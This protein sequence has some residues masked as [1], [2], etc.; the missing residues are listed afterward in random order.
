[1]KVLVKEP[2]KKPVVKERYQ[3]GTI[4]GKR[5]DDMA[6]NQVLAI[7]LRILRSAS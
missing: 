6:Q 4:R 2:K 3:S 7:Y 5:I 1:M